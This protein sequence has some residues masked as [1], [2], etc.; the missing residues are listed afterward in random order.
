M[1]SSRRAY[2]RAL[3]LIELLVVLGI[4]GLLVGLLLP[5]VQAA[6][7]AARRAQCAANLRQLGIAVAHYADSHLAFPLGRL[8]MYDPRY[9]G[10]NP[11]C[12]AARVDKSPLVALLPYLE[13]GPLFDAI[14]HDVSIF[15]LENT[16]AHTI[17]IR[18]YTCPSDPTAYY[19]RQLPPNELAPMAPD[20]PD[21][22][23]RMCAMSYT[24]SFGAFDVVALPSVYPGCGVPPRVRAQSDGV[25]SDI[26]PIR[27]AD[28][29]DGLTQTLFFSEKAVTTFGAGGTGPNTPGRYGWWLSGNLND[30]LFTTLYPPNAYRAT[31][32]AASARYRSASSLH[33]GG[34]LALFGDGSARFLKASID[35]WPF[36]PLTGQPAGA[37]RAAGGWWE[38]LPRPGVW[39]ALATR[40]GGEVIEAPAE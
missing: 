1:E 11:P 2:P 21:G 33:P 19:P 32:T 24:A 13:Q 6:R 16:T 26:H 34:V 9:A 20:P 22:L 4:V 29:S 27:P 38:G 18:A 31:P 36:D 25:F 3:T 15:S 14:N 28:I 17:S 30:A 10:S 39:Q 40:A 5:A 23:R 35:S 12:T 7:E 8:L 37:A